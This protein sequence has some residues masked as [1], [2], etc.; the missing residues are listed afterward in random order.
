[1]QDIFVFKSNGNYLGF[2]RNNFLF[3]RDGNYLGW[4]DNNFI[5]DSHGRFRGML[6]NIQGN[7]Y[8]VSNRFTLKPAPHT[9][10]TSISQSAAPNKNNITPISLP[11]NLEDAF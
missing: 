8:I 6:T 7:Y 3:S 9:P 10:R 1:M 4:L 5:W 11:L 2:I